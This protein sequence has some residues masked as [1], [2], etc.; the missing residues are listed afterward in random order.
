MTVPETVPQAL[1]Q[2]PS[3]DGRKETLSLFSRRESVPSHSFTRLLGRGTPQ[4]QDSKGSA[5]STR[6]L[7]SSGEIHLPTSQTFLVRGKSAGSDQ[8]PSCPPSGY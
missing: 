3:L 5:R 2:S 4:K 6:L 8:T 1:G 7:R